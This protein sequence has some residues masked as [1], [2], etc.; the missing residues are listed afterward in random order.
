MRDKIAQK[1][2]WLNRIVIATIVIIIALWTWWLFRPHPFVLRGCWKVQDHSFICGNTAFSPKGNLLAALVLTPHS[3]LVTILWHIP[4]GRLFKSIVVSKNLRS[5]CISECPVAFSPDGNLL[6]VGYLEQDVGKIG[7][8]SVPDGNRARTIVMGKGKEMPSVTFVP[9][10]QLLA[11]R[12]SGRIW[13]IRLTDGLKSLSSHRTVS[14][15][16]LTDG[17]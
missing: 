3:D 11:V 12:Y 7:I 15:F 17:S 4:N 2:K 6:A 9:N 5:L 14:P 8:F 10:G 1:R 16:P 13:M